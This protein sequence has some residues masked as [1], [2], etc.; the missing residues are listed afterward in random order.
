MSNNRTIL[1]FKA[2]VKEVATGINPLLVFKKLK[3]YNVSRTELM[4]VDS[5]MKDMPLEN[6]HK[7]LILP[8]NGYETMLQN[9]TFKLIE[10]HQTET[11]EE[12]HS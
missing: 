12:E 9:L 11:L 3:K 5:A 10:M 7:T 4:I 8:K 1:E 6:L 2:M